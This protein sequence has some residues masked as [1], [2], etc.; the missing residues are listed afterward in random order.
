MIV[1][2]GGRHSGTF[3]TAAASSSSTVAASTTVAAIAASTTV[4][5]I[6][7][8]TTFCR[9]LFPPISCLLPP[10]NTCCWPK[11]TSFT[12]WSE[13]IVCLLVT[14]KKLKDWKSNPDANRKKLGCDYSAAILLAHSSV[15]SLFSFHFGHYFLL[16]I[17]FN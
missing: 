13:V 2:M 10:P 5:A 16:T 17:Q 3:S 1:C 6:A 11:V 7:A 4:A 8:S 12:F 9:S 15:S 14:S